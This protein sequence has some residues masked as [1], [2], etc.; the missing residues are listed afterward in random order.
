MAELEKQVP[1]H[2]CAWCCDFDFTGKTIE[3]VAAHADSCTKDPTARAEI[4][5]EHLVQSI[6]DSPDGTVATY[7][8]VDQRPGPIFKVEKPNHKE[9]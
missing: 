8:G 5:I 6:L 3:E 7:S 9:I 2:V 1:H 4:P